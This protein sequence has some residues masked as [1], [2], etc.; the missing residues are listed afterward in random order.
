MAPR[1]SLAVVAMAMGLEVADLVDGAAT[2]GGAEVAPPTT[3]ANI[4]TS[5]RS[6]VLV[7]EP[8]ESSFSRYRETKVMSGN[9]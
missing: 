7:S 8:M 1:R 5:P 4:P 2:G 9:V 3:G 6:A